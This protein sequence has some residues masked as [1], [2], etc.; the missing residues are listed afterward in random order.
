MYRLINRKFS[1][2]KS[3]NNNLD[4]SKENNLTNDSDTILTNDSDTILTNKEEE[5]SYD[6]SSQNTNKLVVYC[7]YSLDLEKSVDEIIPEIALSF[8]ENVNT[9]VEIIFHDSNLETIDSV[10]TEGSIY[11]W[12]KTSSNKLSS[13][14]IDIIFLDQD[15]S[16]EEIKKNVDVDSQLLVFI[17]DKLDFKIDF[18]KIIIKDFDHDIIFEKSAEVYSIFNPNIIDKKIIKQDYLFYSLAKQKVVKN[19]FQEKLDQIVK[20][21]K[22]LY[23]DKFSVEHRNKINQMFADFVLYL[24]D[25]SKLRTEFDKINNLE[26]LNDFFKSKLNKALMNEYNYAYLIN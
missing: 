6:V 24:N 16:L 12:E 8:L 17:V 2:K 20:D 19:M 9:K 22:I 26:K 11:N 14:N 3:N 10:K 15:V 7:I 18:G 13:E 23:S 1:I 21:F 25:G 5:K 4:S